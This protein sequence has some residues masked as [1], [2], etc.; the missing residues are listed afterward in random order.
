MPTVAV[1][2]AKRPFCGRDHI[3]A[4]FRQSPGRAGPV[5][6][7]S[8]SVPASAGPTAPALSPW[9]ATDKNQTP[10]PRRSPLEDVRGTRSVKGTAAPAMLADEGRTVC[11][12]A[13]RVEGRG[14][15]ECP[16]P[17]RAGSRCRNLA[18]DQADAVEHDAGR[19]AAV[20]RRNFTPPRCWARRP[21]GSRP[22]R[23]WAAWAHLD[24][25]NTSAVVGRGPQQHPQ[26]RPQQ[27][28]RRSRR[29]ARRGFP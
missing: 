29:V 21:C 4:T 3:P 1:M 22:G 28:G 16:G 7:A 27:Q 23:I 8:P 17:P 15:E 19:A 20:D 14:L 9:K 11:P 13:E 10:L 12:S 6:S 25:M 2:A 26:R 18:V 24:A 5:K